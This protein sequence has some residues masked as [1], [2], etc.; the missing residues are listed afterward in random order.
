MSSMRATRLLCTLSTVAVVLTCPGSAYARRAPAALA[1]GTFTRMTF[2][3]TNG[4]VGYHMFANFG[5]Y[6]SDEPTGDNATCVPAV[7]DTTTRGTIPAGLVL[8]ANDL[9]NN[10][11]VEGF[12]G[13]P[14]QPG[15]WTVSVVINHVKCN[16]GPDQRDYGPKT[17]TVHFHIDP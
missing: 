2:A 7:G 11:G 10:S 13:T 9:P 12:D 15:D 3:N 8:L 17:V 6:S 5:V 14:R 1:A 16:A 4:R